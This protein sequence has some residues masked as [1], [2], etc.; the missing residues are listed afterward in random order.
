MKQAGIIVVILLSFVHAGLSIAGKWE[1]FTKDNTALESNEIRAVCIDSYGVKWFGTANGLTRFDGETWV[2]FTDEEK[3]ADNAVNSI[4][5]ETAK[6][7][8]EIWV[9]TEGGVSVI[10]VVPDAITFATPYTTGNTGL[11]SDRVKAAAVDAG[12]VKWFGTIAGVSSF[13]GKSW[14]SYTTDNL[15]TNNHVLSIGTADDGWIYFGTDGDGV[16]RF[17]G[18]TSASPYDTEWSGIASDVVT[19]VYVAPDGTKWFGTDKGLSRHVGSKTKSGWTT[20]TTKDGLAGDFIY[21][22]TSDDESTLWV[23]T[24]GGASSFD[25]SEWTS[26]TVGDG[27]AGSNVYSVA[28]DADGSVWMGTDAGVS[29]YLG[30]SVSVEKEKAR[31][32]SIAIR[33]CYPNPFNPQTT[34]EYYVPRNGRV[35][36]WICNTAGQR[37]RLL[38]SNIKSTGVHT[39]VW[40]GCDESGGRVSA[41]IYVAVL[42]MGSVMTSSKMVLVK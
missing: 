36:L 21:A 32:A 42:K 39:S 16:T 25:G 41:G 5:F 18:V 3:L 11:I 28:V 10:S 23:G 20:Y 38:V 7:G 9:A 33:G 27:L 12:H 8:P 1:T 17:D 22:I 24:N 30:E 2:T 40:D 26:Y 37:I 13:D 34:I 31:P 35:E 14:A 15:L 19:A 4:V 6:H 29:H